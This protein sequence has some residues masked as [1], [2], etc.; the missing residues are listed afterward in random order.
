M[1][2]FLSRRAREFQTLLQTQSVG[3]FS[4]FNMDEMTEP[5][6]KRAH[7]EEVQEKE[8]HSLEKDQ[9]HVSYHVACI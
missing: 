3:R 1:L 6:A 5:P 7:L 8:D 2:T 9:K 4:Q